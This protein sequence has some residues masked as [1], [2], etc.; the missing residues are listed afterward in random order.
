[1]PGTLEVAVRTGDET[2]TLQ[3]SADT[4]VTVLRATLANRSRA[5]GDDADDDGGGGGGGDGDGGCCRSA[6]APFP[7]LS[8]PRLVHMGALL[9]DSDIRPLAAWYNPRDVVR[10]VPV[11]PRNRPH[12]PLQA[13]AHVAAVTPLCG[14]EAGGTRVSVTGRGFGPQRE[15]CLRFG[16]VLVR[17]HAVREGYRDSDLECWSLVCSTPAHAPGVV[18]VDA[19]SEGQLY[20]LGGG[21]SFTFLS[22]RQW[23]ALVAQV[24]APS[25]ARGCMVAASDEDIV[26]AAC[27]HRRN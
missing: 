3:L 6:T 13:A 9:N 27:A 17:A 18:S 11:V 1:M 26:S 19:L 10:V 22:A 7:S 8:P 25:H 4:T 21:G 5:G 23:A 12:S 2:Y 14:P 20:T 24:A 16:T 15:W